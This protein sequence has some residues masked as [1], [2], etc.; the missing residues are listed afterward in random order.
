MVF[1]LYLNQ[2]TIINNNLKSSTQEMNMQKNGEEYELFVQ[3]I[4]KILNCADGLKD[5]VVQHDVKIEGVSREHQIDVYWQFTCGTVTYRVAV[6]CKDYKNPVTAEK[7]EAFRAT[8]LDIG[9]I[10][11][12][13]AA[14]NGFQSGAQKVA[15]TY[16]IQLVQI[17]EPLESDWRG[18]IKDI[19]IN[20]TFRFVVNV[21]PHIYVNKEWIE[22][23]EIKQKI[24]GFKEKSDQTYIVKNKGLTNE[25]RIT[26]KQLIDKLPSDE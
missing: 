15:K 1:V 9:D 18:Y 5:V 21:R 7:I 24:A 12:I 8:L 11:G 3:D 10:H 26:V 17:R 25:D 6:E 19:H 20:Y 16:G 22:E 13:F 2:N 14:R 23:N 4:Y